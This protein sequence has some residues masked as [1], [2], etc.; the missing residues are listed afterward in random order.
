MVS[1]DDESEQEGS[2]NLVSS[3]DEIEP[4][5]GG[6]DED[7]DGVGKIVFQELTEQETRELFKEKPREKLERMVIHVVASAGKNRAIYV[8]GKRMFA[9]AQRGALR[10]YSKQSSQIRFDIKRKREPYMWRKFDGPQA[11][12]E[13]MAFAQNPA[14][15]RREEAEKRRE[16]AGRERGQGQRAQPCL[17]G[18]YKDMF[19]KVPLPENA[20]FNA[21]PQQR[22]QQPDPEKIDSG[23]ARRPCDA[24]RHRGG[25]EK[26]VDHFTFVCKAINLTKEQKEFFRLCVRVSRRVY[27]MCVA[28]VRKWEK[29]WGWSYGTCPREFLNDMQNQT[30]VTYFNRAVFG[31]KGEITEGVRNCAEHIP[32]NGRTLERVQREVRDEMDAVPKAVI[33]SAIRQADMAYRSNF[34]KIAKAQNEGRPYKGFRVHFRSSSS[35]SKSDVVKFPGKEVMQFIEE[36]ESSDS[37]SSSSSD[38]VNLVSSDSSSSSSSEEVNLV[39]SGEEA[40]GENQEQQL[41]QQQPPPPPPPPP[42][43]QEQQRKKKHF[44][45]QFSARTSEKVKNTQFTLR[46]SSKVVDEILENNGAK[47]VEKRI[48]YDGKTRSYYVDIVIK[49]EKTSAEGAKKTI[50]WDLGINPLTTG[51]DTRG[52]VVKCYSREPLF[53][54]RRKIDALA[55]KIAKRDYEASK[56]N[57]STRTRTQYR[58]TTR[59]LKK[60]LVKMRQQLKRFTSNYH[61]IEIKKNFAD[62]DIVLVNRLNVKDIAQKSKERG[63]LSKH[64]RRNMYTMA[65]A[66]F[67]DRLSHVARRTPGKKVVLGCGEEMTSQTCTNCGRVNENLP[68][69]EKDFVCPHCGLIIN[70]DE[71]ACSNIGKKM[72]VVMFKPNGDEKEVGGEQD[73]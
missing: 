63:D 4:E 33:Y 22:Q 25:K 37:S 24:R 21:E 15:L 49:R 20:R 39:S 12:E 42:P 27:N 58:R 68:H 10:H 57:G 32:L 44:V 47:I 5:D 19:N 71:N 34:A 26:K 9:Q 72:I 51:V 1:S 41:L 23:F 8:D 52:K 18:S 16:G 40:D 48:R 3:D 53:D 11:K 46:Q 50:F 36:V 31:K 28:M 6:E 73:Q 35:R 69:L 61:Y 38:E 65:P 70:R 56:R 43:P 60:K 55:S 54:L 59:T 67:V 13:A 14:V 66:L 45:A 30:M 7:D 29:N 2:V 64:G 17:P 62:N